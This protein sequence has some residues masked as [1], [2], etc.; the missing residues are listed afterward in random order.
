MK[1]ECISFN[2]RAW[3]IWLPFWVTLVISIS[4]GLSGCALMAQES[5]YGYTDQV[6][7]EKQFEDF[8]PSNFDRS[9]TIDNEWWPLKPGTQLIYEGHTVEDDE[10][11]PHRIVFTVTD[12]TKVI[13]GV[14]TVVIFDRD[15]SND[16]LEEAELAFFAQDNDG[17]VW[18]LGQYRE[19]YD[20]MEFVGGRMWVVGHLEGAKAGIMMKAQ[21]QVGM[22][23]YSQGYAPAP[24]NWTDRARTYQMDQKITVPAGSYKDVLVTEEFNE[25][26]PGA[27][28]LK[29][30]AR[31]VGNVRV[32]WKGDDAQKEELELVEVVKL[33]GKAL[34]EVRAQAMELEK[35]AYV[36]GS[37]P[38]AK[39]T[40]QPVA[41]SKNITEDMSEA[42][43]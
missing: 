1:A 20:E 2:Q 27:F 26:E 13:N 8:N 17:N 16:R 14:R 18:H 9:T 39:H 43:D 12:L 34:A 35:R 23:D 7:A 40:L 29:Y 5:E 22:P 38:P 10:K 6:H 19:V 30:Y 42:I 31:G 21:P 32:G 4:L 37:T 41:S 36:Y 28:Q 33:S 11:I 15:Y 3:T 24:F 25:E